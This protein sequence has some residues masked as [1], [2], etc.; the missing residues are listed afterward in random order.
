MRHEALAASERVLPAGALMDPKLKVELQD[1]TK[2]GEQGP[3]LLP[4]NV[5]SAPIP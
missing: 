4:S 1:L 2:G 5:G 3:T